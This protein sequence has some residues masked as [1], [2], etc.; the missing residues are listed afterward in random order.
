MR[1]RLFPF[2]ILMIGALAAFGQSPQNI[3]L[4]KSQPSGQ[5]KMMACDDQFAGTFEIANFVGQSNTINKDTAFLC[6]NDMFDVVHNGDADLTGD[7]NTATTPGVTYI[8][9]ECP[10]TIDG[11]NFDAI[12]M[13]NCLFLGSP[14]PT[15]G[16][17]VTAGGNFN[18]NQT[19]NNPG[20]LQNTFN[21][22]D[23]LLL[24]F[25]PITIDHFS[26]K[27]Y[28]NDVNGVTGPCVHLNEDEAFAVVYL[29]G[30]ELTDLNT[31][32]GSS[33][34]SGSINVAGGLPEFDGSGYDISISLVGSSSVQ[35]TVT[36]NNPVTHGGTISF[37]VPAPGLYEITV[38]DGKSCGASLIA[39]M[40]GCVNVSQ[41]MGSGIIPPG[42]NICLDVTVEGGFTD[43]QSFQYAITY[44]PSVLQFTNVQDFTAQLP[45]FNANNFNIAN[46]TLRVTWLDVGGA[47]LADGSVVFQVCFDAVG[48]D[49]ECTEVA[50]SELGPITDIEII[51]VNDNELGF[52]G[53]SGLVC[54]SN[55]ALQAVASQDSV[56]CPGAADGGFEVTVAGG[57]PPYEITWQN[58]MGGPVLGPG[59]INVNGGTFSIFNLPE[60]LYILTITDNSATPNTAVEVVEI[61]GPPML[62]ILFSAD[63][64]QCNG[65]M[66]S[67]T[68]A[69]VLDSVQLTDVSNYTFDWSNGGSTPTINNITAGNYT[70]EVTDNTTGCTVQDMTFLPQ[71]ALLTVDITIDSATCTG[72]A[73]GV[74]MV[75]VS[76]GVPN[77]GG[78]YQIELGASSVMGTSASL[79]AESGEYQLLVTDDNGCTVEQ[80]IELPA[81]KVLSITPTITNVDCN[82]D[83]TGRIFAQGTTDGGTPAI[84]YSFTWSG[85]PNPPASMDTPTF[86][87]LDNLCIGTYTVVMQDTD[88][89][90]VD[91]TFEIVQPSPLVLTLVD[92]QDET[93]Q[94]G[95]DGSITV[96]VSGGAF[97]YS[98]D[99]NDPNTPLTD[100]IASNLSAGIYTVAVT[101]SEGCLAE[102]QAEVTLPDPPVILTLDDDMIDCASEM[103]GSLT[104]VPAD[105]T[106]IIQTNW[107]NGGLTETISDLGPGEYIVTITDVNQC[108]AVD[109]ALVTAPP[110]LVLDSVQLQSPSCLGGSDGE[111]IVVVSGG[112]GTPYNYIWSADPTVNGATFGQAMAGDYL[113]SITDANNCQPGLE[114]NVTLEEPPFILETFSAI[115]SVSCA[116]TGT[117][118]DGGATISVQYSDGS[119]GVFDF[120]WLGSGETTN[121]AATSTASILCQ[122]DQLVQV[123]DQ[124]CVDTFSVFIPSPP[125]IV[126]GQSIDNVSCNGL[127]DGVIT[128]MPN[129]GTPPYSIVWGNGTVGPVLSGL[130]AGNYTA[131]ITDAKNCS[132]THTVTVIEPDPLQLTLDGTLTTPN[133]SCA[134]D[135]DGRMAVIATGG[136]ITMLMDE[137]YI[138]Q[139]NVG[140]LTSPVATDLSA[141]TYS[142]TVVDSKGCEADISY[143]IGEPDPIDFI[144]ADIPEI[145]CFG[146]NTSIAIDS[147]WGGTSSLRF[148]VDGMP[149]NGAAIDQSIGGL[150]A[151]VHLVTVFD[152][153]DCSADTTVTIPQPPELQ[154]TF[155]EDEIEIELGDS[156]TSLD[157]IIVPPVPIDTF[158]WSPPTQLSCHDCKNPVVTPVDDQLYTLVVIDI[159]GCT[160][161]GS[162]FV[163]LDRNRNVYIPNIFSPNGD[164]INDDFKVYTGPGVTAINFVRI[165]DRWGNL[166][167]D[168]DDPIPSNA[169]TADW[170]GTFKGDEMN[171][172]VF[173]YLIEVEFLDGQVLVYR[174]DISLIK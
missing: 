19:F 160:A 113:V 151:N 81:I 49:G 33:G 133:V 161:S 40:A 164:G 68:A 26:D 13:D 16:F 15:N 86:S 85:I 96:A 80:S 75:N 111:I 116:N 43:I 169:G 102:I 24:W 167:H 95:M 106:N 5:E 124:S 122:G 37:D 35:G 89:C 60:G 117:S 103:D 158:I 147:A 79:M 10:P 157:P 123:A 93:C 73:D 153:N 31:N 78:D 131:V 53:I 84:P 71:P 28:E 118:C 39:N 27:E 166:V 50:F 152:I 54:I 172:A 168:V 57:T 74:I 163:D 6:L 18:G 20:A 76:G 45:N 115:D 155:D 99:W 110:P 139:N 23:P 105:P 65:D 114:V 135:N 7:P 121:N 109:T 9:L 12:L 14:P 21:N 156:S 29:N 88:G 138:W 61:L 38:E 44:D 67:L 83:C 82:N 56:S 25:A 32:A 173:L 107:S 119:T 70:L 90:E 126:P 127:A 41:S 77:A 48:D 58:S 91:S 141:G 101:D 112:G 137:T 64:G 132:F 69:L 51:D 34:C 2:T 146:G 125:P 94:P 148:R 143:T 150:T 108:T 145:D 52:N 42:E 129:G 171:P 63:Q 46:D 154:V 3:S 55:S 149:P 11:P 97:P 36:N 162:I 22:G 165:Y 59:T 170:D 87:V 134:G 130:T 159:N 104:V 92:V 142:V 30:I 128:L 62:N 120:T 72:I 66:G 1:Y 100:S 144:L 47:S 174:G 17:Y 4:N 136:N 140:A 98:Y 8:L